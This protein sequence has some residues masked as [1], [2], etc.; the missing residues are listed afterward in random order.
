MSTTSLFNSWRRTDLVWKVINLCSSLDQPCLAGCCL[1]LKEFV[2]DPTVGP[3]PQWLVL[4]DLILPRLLS[5][6]VLLHCVHSIEPITNLKSESEC[7]NR[8][9]VTVACQ[10]P[11]SMEFSRQEYWSEL[12]FPTPMDLPDPWV[13]PGSLALEADSLLSELPGKP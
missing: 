7:F 1:M 2:P 10:V 12:L 13:E 3:R 8:S 11:L 4:V 6:R 9:V 5:N